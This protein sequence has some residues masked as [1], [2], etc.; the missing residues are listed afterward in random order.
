MHAYILPLSQSLSLGCSKNRAK[1][2]NE[3]CIIT[4][5][6]HNVAKIIS[7]LATSMSSFFQIS[8]IHSVQFVIQQKAERE[9]EEIADSHREL[10][11]KRKSMLA[12][13]IFKQVKQENRAKNEQAL[14]LHDR[15]LKWKSMRGLFLYA[16]QRKEKAAELHEIKKEL[17]RRTAIRVCV[18]FK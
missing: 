16:R 13:K 9:K 5:S 2:E 7:N 15:M 1:S 11:L 3:L 4:P 12:L 10:V 8:Y 17:L 14:A 18:S 6:T